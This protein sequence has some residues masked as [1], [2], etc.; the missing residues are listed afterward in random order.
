M[1]EATP[2]QL[3]MDYVSTNFDGKRWW[4]STTQSRELWTALNKRVGS[5]RAAQLR[6]N[7]VK[8]LKLIG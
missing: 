7:A 8:T 5:N 4:P 6:H 2:E 3:A 1:T